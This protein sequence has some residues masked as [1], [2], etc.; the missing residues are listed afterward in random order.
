LLEEYALHRLNYIFNT[1]AEFVGSQEPPQLDEAK[2]FLLE[3]NLSKAGANLALRLLQGEG[4][5]IG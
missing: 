5:L 3:H 4:D 1:A 2:K